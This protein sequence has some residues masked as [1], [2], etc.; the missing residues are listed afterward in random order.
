MSADDGPRSGREVAYR[1]FAAEYDDA[2]LEH[3]ESDEERA[4][5]YV[6]TPTGARVNRLFAVGVL[7]QIES[8]AE[9]VLRARVADPT[10]A[11]VVYAGQYQPEAVAFLEDAEPPAF[12]AVTGKARTFRPD[13]ADRVYT[14]V[15]P[16]SVTEV[17]RATRDR[18]VVRTAEHTLDRVATMAEAL[19]RPERGDDLRAVLEEAGVQPGL[20]AG[21]PL[22]VDHYGTTSGYL[23]ALRDVALDAVRVVTGDVEE[24]GDLSLAPDE[25]GDS[26]ADLSFDGLAGADGTDVAGA[27]APTAATSGTVAADEASGS[28]VAGEA[29]DA[30]GDGAETGTEDD[31]AGATVAADAATGDTA[32]E[33]SSATDA[34]ED[35]GERDGRET[36]EQPP[37][38]DRGVESEGAADDD[39]D[40]PGGAESEGAAD[41]EEAEEPALDEDE[42]EAVRE[43]HD[44]GFQS[45]NDVPDAGEAG[46]ETPDAEDVAADNEGGGD[47]EESVADSAGAADADLEDAVVATM[48]E[49]ADGDGVAQDDLVAA[50]AEAEDAD[51]EAVEAAVQDALMAGRCYQ[52]GD[53]ELTPI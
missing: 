36:P 28:T 53:D 45:G 12:V 32:D 42:R 19:E 44:V 9:D 20:A 27:A 10:G 33:P 25:G 24:A 38:D 21:I 7:T 47:A 39:A 4:P 23:A 11:F 49:M 46:I 34:A 8:V 37:A 50:V 30:A 41:D 43:E 6:V 26:D 2:D 14:S 35:D 29:A 16:E 22:A 52:S 3:S 31:G 51:E 1:L 5:N 13:D 15:R 48:R 17:D 40:G 18:W